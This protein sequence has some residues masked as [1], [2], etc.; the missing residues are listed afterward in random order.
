MNFSK[1]PYNVNAHLLNITGSHA[2]TI[3]VY[4]AQV[5]WHNIV[6]VVAESEHCCFG[7]AC[8]CVMTAVHRKKVWDNMYSLYFSLSQ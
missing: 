7:C 8:L 5:G 6:S 1:L 4:K 3:P 2:G